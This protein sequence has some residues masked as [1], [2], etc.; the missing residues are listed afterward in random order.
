MSAIS[1][2]V[3]SALGFA[4]TIAFLAAKPAEAVPSFARQTG[5]PAQPAMSAPSVPSSQTTVENSS[6]TDIRGAAVT[7]K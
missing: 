3:G 1:A 7:R 6:F 2:R 5:R 4:V